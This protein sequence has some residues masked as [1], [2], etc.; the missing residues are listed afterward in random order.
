MKKWPLIFLLACLACVGQKEDPEPVPDPDV[1]EAPQGEAEGT[2]FFHRVLALEFTGTW[3]QYCPRMTQ[4]MEDAKELRP[5]RIVDIAVHCYDAFSPAVSDDFAME[6]KIT[7]FPS[8]V[9]DMDAQT[10]FGRSEPSIFVSYVDKALGTAACGLAMSYSDGTLTVKVKAVQ[11]GSYNLLVAV[12]EDGLVAN[13]SGYGANYVNKSVLRKLLV[14]SVKG[15]SLGT[16]A[17]N[18]EKAVSFEVEPIENQRF[19]ASVLQNGK[20]LNALS[21]KPNENIPYSYEKDDN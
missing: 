19:V 4:A 18:E 3:C 6:F 20:S 14:S 15:D 16:L 21:C 12:V 13:Q 1:P 10:V 7:A 9:L 17:A 11:Q 8:V 5:G 2:R